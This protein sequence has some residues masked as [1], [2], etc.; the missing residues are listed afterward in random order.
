MV[1]IIICPICDT[2]QSHSFTDHIPSDI[3]DLECQE[4]GHNIYA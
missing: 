2:V 3:R 1:D 4:C